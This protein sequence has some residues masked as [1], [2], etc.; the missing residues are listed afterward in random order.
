MSTSPALRA[1][2]VVW[3]ASY[4]KSGNTWVQT[5]MRHA[6]KSLGFPAG[7][8]DVYKLMADGREPQVV[9]GVAP[10]IGSGRTAVLK[11]HNS[12]DGQERMHPALRLRTAGFVYVL[13][14]P[15]DVLLSYINFTRQQYEKRKDSEVYQENLFLN[16]LGFE[17][18]FTYDEWVETRLEDIPRKNLDHALRRFGELDT[19]IPGLT[20]I[21][22]GSWLDHANSWHAAAAQLPSV[23]LRYEDLLGGWQS[24]KPLK[25]LFSFQDEDLEQAVAAINEKQRSLQYK[26]VFYNK[27][28]A[29]Y[30]K[31]FFSQDEVDRFLQKFEPRLKELGYASLYA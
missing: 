24:F 25:T 20:G 6:G 10:G 16:L 4:P 5:V 23:V 15:L 31:E 26:T 27:M 14:N 29:Y 22:G 28:S 1:N 8:L 12:Y 30:F 9:K 19:G 18:P 2:S 17:R 7:D 13:R 11:T 3:I 21:A